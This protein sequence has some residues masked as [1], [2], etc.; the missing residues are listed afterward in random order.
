M[1]PFHH[2]VDHRNSFCRAILCK[3]GLCRHA[4]SVSLCVCPSRSCILSKRINASSKLF[5]PSRGLGVVGASFWGIG[6]AG[7]RFLLSVSML[8]CLLAYWPWVGWHPAHDGVKSPGSCSW[9]GERKRSWMIGYLCSCS[10]CA[11][12]RH[13]EQ[14][15]DLWHFRVF[16]WSPARYRHLVAIFD[17]A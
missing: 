14:K 2:V 11:V 10:R 3:R 9:L 8:L 13:L 1:K 6:L 17:P 16:G 12:T 5:S 7:C 15:Y 4:V